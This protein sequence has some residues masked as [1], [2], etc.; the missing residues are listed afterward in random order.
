[1]DGRRGIIKVKLDENW[2][3]VA[4]RTISSNYIFSF[5]EF[6]SLSIWKVFRKGVE[7]EFYEAHL[8]SKFTPLGKICVTD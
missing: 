8:A 6:K 4:V 3:F 5:F 2:N 7:I 1:M